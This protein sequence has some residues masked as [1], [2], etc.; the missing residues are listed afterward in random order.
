MK[1]I[2]SN[3]IIVSS[4]L[5][6][7]L[8]GCSSNKENDATTVSET[9]VTEEATIGDAASVD[10]LGDSSEDESD[11]VSDK[12][13]DASEM[14]TIDEVVEEGMVPIYADQINDGVYEVTVS[15]SSSMFKIVSCELTVE[16]GEMTA[17]MNM[18]GT[19]YLYLYPGTGIE[20]AGADEADYIEF[21]E[22][23]EGNHSF[24]FPVDALDEGIPCAA[25]SKNKEKWYDRTI[26]FRV[27]SLPVEAFKEGVF[28][29]VSSLELEDGTYS[30]EVSLA[31]GS[32]KASVDSPT[33][34]LIENGDV[35]ATIVWS[36]SNYDYM[37]VNDE[38]Y[39]PI[40]TEGNSVFEIPVTVFDRNI[41]VIADTT[42][43][44]EPHEIEYTLNFDSSSIKNI[45]E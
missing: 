23:E 9:E 40:N 14:T 44:S 22:N 18:S 13:A 33:N 24:E 27:D 8:T 28:T 3:I 21:I 42:A 20:A 2:F 39:L 29:T 43:M 38:K 32:G 34:L 41:K 45:E 37:L 19:S 5:I 35:T 15:S 6:F 11:D 12:V 25:Y 10:V 1:K 31:G 36:S 7:G 4:V 17:L 26:L 30:V 16:D